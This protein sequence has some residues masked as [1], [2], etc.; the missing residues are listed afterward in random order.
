MRDRPFF[1]SLPALTGAA[2]LLLAVPIILAQDPPTPP[3]QA[4]TRVQKPAAPS[5]PETPAPVGVLDR[6]RG[7][8]SIRI[9]YRTDARPFS[10][11]NESGVAAGYSVELC[12]HIVEAVRGE[13]GSRD[14]AVDWVPLNAGERFEALK[15][16][17][18]D[19]L[20]GAETV[21]L[22]RRADASFSIPVFP[23]GVGALVR[24][25][26]PARL[27]E[28]LAGRGQARPVWRASAT[29][30]VQSR[31]LSAVQG[32][33]AE[34]WLLERIG[35]LQ[36]I[37]S[38]SRQPGYDAGVQALVDRRT[39]VL[40]GER[41]ILLDAA[42]RHR[43]PGE[44]IVIDRLFTYE[45][46]AFALA[47]GD[48]SLRLVVDRTLSRLQASGELGRVYANWFAEPDDS[49]LTFFRWNALPE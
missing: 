29:Q 35:E 41:A 3:G 20:C 19:L 42:R 44:L 2:L 39:D 23:G 21:T 16:R 47:R 27:R 30:A 15:Q 33:T 25:D 45:P 28:A 43:V 37:A 38:V 9:G 17:R 10:F 40:F 34:R 49:T 24:A 36:I 26:A 31:F 8:G 32:T 5:T 7:G 13:I 14:L 1:R 22:S 18:V 11:N 48:E 4:A 6:L 12:R 46:L